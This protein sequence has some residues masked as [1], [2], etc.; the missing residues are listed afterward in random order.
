[1]KDVRILLVEDEVILSDKIARDL[2]EQEYK[3]VAKIRYGEEVLPFLE[4]NLAGVDIILLD[5]TLAGEM[6]GIEVAEL[7]QHKKYFFPIIYLTN[8]KENEIIERALQTGPSSYLTKDFD[9]DDLDIAIRLAV[10]RWRILRMENKTE[11]IEYFFLHDDAGYKRLK[12][13]DILWIEAN[14]GYCKIHLKGRVHLQTFPMARFNKDYSHPYLFQIHR[15]YTA[16]VRRIT[17]IEKGLAFIEEGERATK[18]SIK[19]GKLPIGRK[20]REGLYKKLG[21][22]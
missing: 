4:R 10:Q 1:M 13:A 21:I 8:N 22:K 5:I 19:N 15:S 7:L 20:F 6:D 16:N 17:K 12:V 11:P 14:K 18:T 2:A 9:I 3:V